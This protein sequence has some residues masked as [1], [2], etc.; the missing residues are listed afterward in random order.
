M[1]TSRKLALAVTATLAL[2]VGTA[3]PAAA[4]GPFPIDVVGGSF[5]S[6][7]DF[8]LTPGS[9][10]SP[11]CPE[12]ATTLAMTFD[13]TTTSGTWTITGSKARQTQFP[14]G[15]AGADWYQLDV[16][17][18]AG[19]GGTYAAVGS[20]PPTDTLTGTMGIRIRVYRIGTPASP[21]CSKTDLR[22]IITG[23]FGIT[24]GDFVGNPLPN[25]LPG[26][27]LHLTSTTIAPLVTS[28]CTAP[29]FVL[30]GN[31]ATLDQFIEFQ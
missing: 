27:D 15:S 19:S 10:G 21:N 18:L 16:T 28:S 14:T 29:F 30:G 4:N 22:C 12:K 6:I 23:A 2:L 13:G 25:P 8:D 5:D 24:S 3:T 20:P 1:R 26:D 7:V 17:Y 31:P 11:P 9:Q